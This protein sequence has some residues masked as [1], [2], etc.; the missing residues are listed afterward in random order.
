MLYVSRRVGVR[1]YGV[2][3][4]DDDVETIVKGS[5]LGNMVLVD[6]VE[7]VG[8]KLSSGANGTYIRGFEMYQDP[9]YYTALQAKYKTLKGIDIRTYKGEITY[10]ALDGDRME[11]EERIVLSKFGKCMSWKVQ[12]IWKGR[13]CKEQRVIL[14]IDD[15]I[16]MLG[17]VTECCL[18]GAA[19]DVS[20]C[21]NEEL[22]T[23]MYTDAFD[24]EDLDDLVIDN[25][26]VD[27]RE[28]MTYW[29]C[30]AMLNSRV[31]DAQSYSE[32]LNQLQTPEICRKLGDKYKS[33]FESFANLEFG[34]PTILTDDLFDLVDKY[35]RRG[36]KIFKPEHFN[37]L[38]RNFMSVVN[39]F[40]QGT[41]KN[42]AAVLRF[43]N[44]FRF[45]DTPEDMVE[46][47]IRFCNN[48][49]RVCHEE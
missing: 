5:D 7:I 21:H 10:I 31:R 34:L 26:I 19:W 2:V 6:K 28:R 25:F 4:T 47:Y 20:E 37:Y 23:K 24:I 36:I 32:R 22:V 41:N 13:Q 11:L 15:N 9:R 8:V 38:R 17:D 16:E 43:G 30:Y 33:E 18:E 27:N 12:F 42:Y 29:R 44:Y 49:M 39:T 45:F 40:R 46:I 35:R 1:S 3:D 14:V 48:I